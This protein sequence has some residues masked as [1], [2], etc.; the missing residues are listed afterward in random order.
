MF[1]GIPDGVLTG[2][3]TADTASTRYEDRL[4]QN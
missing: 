1:A 4:R 2:D 3:D